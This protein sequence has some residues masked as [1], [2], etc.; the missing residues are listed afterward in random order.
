MPKKKRGAKLTHAYVSAI[1]DPGTYGDGYGS[2][3]LSLIVKARA[4]GGVR[5]YWSQRIQIKGKKRQVGLGSFPQVLL[6]EARDKVADHVRRVAQGED[7]LKPPPTIPTVA[8]GFEE[9]IADRADSWEGKHTEY[10][11]RLAL[12]YCKKIGSTLVSEVTEDDV[13]KILRPLWH[14]KPKSAKDLRAQ[15]SAVMQLAIRRGHRALAN[16]VPVKN[17]V[18]RILGRQPLPVHHKSLNYRQLGK[19]L[20]TVRDSDTWWAAKYC[21]I[22]IA[23]T[24][25]RSSEARLATWA[26]IDWDTATWTIPADR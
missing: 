26:E 12:R 25:V 10:C 9:L 18:T 16:P 23:F 6:A 4:K 24:C 2:N 11:W 13:I 17:D 20:A 8:Q 7:I 5:K 22:L 21:L 3:G 1:K 14:D 15:L 19:A